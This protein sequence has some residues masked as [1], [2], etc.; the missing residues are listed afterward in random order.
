M[1]VSKRNFRSGVSGIKIEFAV[2]FLQTARS[3]WTLLINRGKEILILTLSPAG[4]EH[5]REA[6]DTYT[7]LWRGPSYMAVSP[8]C[9]LSDVRSCSTA[10]PSGQHSE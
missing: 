10:G 9:T 6:G 1:R 4:L 2:L 5:F 7:A 3:C 8:P